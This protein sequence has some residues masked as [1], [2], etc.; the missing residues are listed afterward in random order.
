MLTTSSLSKI[1][2]NDNLKYRKIPFGN[3]IM[4]QSLDES[5]FPQ[6]DSLSETTFFQAYRNWL[7]VIDMIA[8]PEVTV[9]WY[10]HHSRILHDK[11]FSLSFDAWWDMDKQLQMQFINHPFTINLTCSTYFHLLEHACMDAFLSQCAKTQQVFKSHCSFQSY[12]PYQ[13]PHTES[14]CLKCML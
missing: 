1:H 3:S 14:I 2:S 6:E 11:C 12:P 5:S 7:I 9:G 8:M 10:K 4:K 13:S